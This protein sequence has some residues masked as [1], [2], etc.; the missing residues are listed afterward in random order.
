[1]KGA[2]LATAPMDVDPPDSSPPVSSPSATVA[3]PVHPIAAIAAQ[4]ALSIRSLR[5]NTNNNTIQ[6]NRRVLPVDASTSTLALIILLST[7]VWGVDALRQMQEQALTTMFVRGRRKL[8]LVDK[9]GGGK[10]HVMRLMMTMLKGIHLYFCPLL[11]LMADVVVKFK[12][13]CDDYGAI[14]VYNLDEI[15]SKSSK[16]RTDIIARLR[17]LQPTSTTTIILVASPQFLATH[18]GFVDVLVKECIPNKTLRSCVIDEAHIWAEHGT[19]F[20]VDM[21]TLHETFF[22]P[23]FHGKSNSNSIFFLAATATMSLKNLKGLTSLTSIGFGP[24]DM[25]WGSAEQFEQECITMTCKIGSEYVKNI[26]ETVRVLDASEDGSAFLFANSKALTHRLLLALEKKM[27]EKHVTSDVVHIH[28]SMNKDEKFG[29]INLFTG[30]LVITDYDPRVLVA[31]SSADLGI[32]RSDGRIVTIFEWPDSMSTVA[33]RRGRGSRDGA[34]STTLVVAGLASY[35]SMMK[36]IYRE[37]NAVSEDAVDDN[38]TM[39]S[40]N[41]TA[42]SPRKRQPSKQSTATMADLN[43]TKNQRKNNMQGQIN[44]VMDVLDYYCLNKGCLHRRLELYLAN[45]EMTPLPPDTTPC[46]DACAVCIKDEWEHFFRPVWKDGV[47]RW[48]TSVVRDKFIGGTKA[49]LDNIFNLVCGQPYWIKAIFDRAPGTIYKYN[50][51]S[52]LLQLIAVGII[53]AVRRGDQLHWILVCDVVK[54]DG[55]EIKIPMYEKD[56]TWDGMNL[57]KPTATR[58]YKLI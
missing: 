36:R 52:F 6:S 51:E 18:T 35:L 47:L 57:V 17:R 34:P 40:F 11:A 56:E 32:D 21:R 58:K 27:D 15:A 38:N 30:A 12:Q 8:L 48:L 53:S 3:L 14:E 7:L 5:S 1:M 19:S 46:G 54:V 2:S 24:E 31:T 10:S 42:I 25:V 41:L 28:G 4:S 49:T 26:D 9:T 39:V 45:G 23:I 16:I 50:I 44:A 37:G 55:C 22:K 29:A 20:R 13:G 43:L 33:Q